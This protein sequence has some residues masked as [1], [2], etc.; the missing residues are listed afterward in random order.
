M[1]LR[2]PSRSLA[3]RLM[4]LLVG[5][6]FLALTV[7]PAASLAQEPAAEP[8]AVPGT[9]TVDDLSDGFRRIGNGWRASVG[10]YANHHFWSPARRSQSRIGIWSV[11]FDEPGLYKVLAKLPRQHA[12]SRKTVYK[13]KT[14][15]G[16]T[17][18]VRNQSANRGSWVS[19]GIHRLAATA[20]VRLSDR[21]LDPRGSRRKLA[22]D[23]IRF[24]PLEPPD[25]PV[26][27][28]LDVEPKHD[29]AIVTFSLAE[30]G[31]AKT[32]YRKVG[33]T[34]WRLGANE[35]S[36]KY[37]D[38]RQVIRDLKAETD[39]ELRVIATNLGG[40]T[41]SPITRFRTLAPPLPIIKS[42]EVRPE[43]T[44]AIV[45]FS[46]AEKGPAR[47]D[48]RE[49]G[50]ATWTLG[51]EETS[52]KYADHRHVIKGLDAETTYELR[53]IATNEGGKTASDIVGFTTKPLTVDCGAGGDLQKAID[54][55][56]PGDTI[57]IKGICR[58]NFKV[59]K[60]LTLRGIGTAPEL[61]NP[62]SWD[63][64]V[65]INDSEV[66]I[67]GLKLTGGNRNGV[68]SE[69]PLTIKDFAITD[70]G[71]GVYA[72]GPLTIKDGAIRDTRKGV[73]AGSSLTMSRT[74]VAV[75]ATG[76]EFDGSRASFNDVVVHSGTT[77]LGFK[78]QVDIVDSTIR[79]NSGNGITIAAGATVT[80]SGSKVT[81]NGGTAI[82]NNADGAVLQ[83]SG[84]RIANN[85]RGGISNRGGA[86]A[87][88]RDSVIT[89]NKAGQGGGIYN[90]S[91]LT[92]I[93]SAVTWNL[94]SAGGGIYNVGTITIEDTVIE[95]N[96]PNDC[97][98]C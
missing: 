27:T 48:Y 89:N 66:A 98:G 46:L 74:T 95:N 56:R 64:G 3:M 96:T 62:S 82:A 8:A 39:Y 4:G 68:Y 49:S 6:V 34:T 92:L 1:G 14:Q 81:D 32:E 44:R 84:S 28:R 33:D 85:Q 23:A 35:T 11:T 21:T 40:K 87:V 24:V 90:D 60:D 12:S 38:H 78:G 77:G 25:P 10:G 71:T 73:Y 43:D 59:A 61:R 30:A 37:A 9:V 5:L 31:P 94:A 76:V 69:G 51:A 50:D 2:G 91:T 13:I 70:T 52:S 17:K 19:L 16:W 83:V 7:A 72:E 57:N 29:R 88:I 93:G 26:I 58:G 63:D 41:I 22:F 75:K 54:K 42:I 47:S 15:D 67:I 65:R 20:E 86:R 55:A 80:I 18:R 36:S 45:T 79:D 97:V 53:I